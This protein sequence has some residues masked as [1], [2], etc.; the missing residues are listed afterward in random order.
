[1]LALDQDT[2]SGPVAVSIYAA[3]ISCRRRLIFHVND[4]TQPARQSDHDTVHCFGVQH[5]ATRLLACPLRGKNRRLACHI[6]RQ[7]IIER[8]GWEGCK[9]VR[10]VTAQLLDMLGSNGW[11]SEVA[12]F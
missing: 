2:C 1:M 6:R 11:T 9:R 12:A 10:Q 5:S 8:Q 7:R 3:A 4:Y